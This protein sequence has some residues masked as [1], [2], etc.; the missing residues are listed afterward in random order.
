MFRKLMWCHHSAVRA[1]LQ[2]QEDYNQSRGQYKVLAVCMSSMFFFPACAVI[3][4][5]CLFVQQL[6]EMPT[7]SCPPTSLISLCFQLRKDFLLV[8]LV[9][10]WTGNSGE[11]WGTVEDRTNY[12]LPELIT[13]F[14]KAGMN[15]Q[16]KN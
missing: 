15:V 1:H 4:K 12:I 10:M 3:D 9:S 14:C 6:I 8:L 2:C 11:R 16:V 13:V 5:P 7:C